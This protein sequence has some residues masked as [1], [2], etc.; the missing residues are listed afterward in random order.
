MNWGYS[1]EF[2]GLLTLTG[3]NE[4]DITF[5]NSSVLFEE[6]SDFHKYCHVET[7]DRVAKFGGYRKHNKLQSIC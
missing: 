5:V 4:D 1:Q 6:P 2:S 7:T 3:T